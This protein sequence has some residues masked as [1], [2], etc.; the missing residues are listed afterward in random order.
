[1]TTGETLF[2]LDDEAWKNVTDVFSYVQLC[3]IKSAGSGR[4]KR[5]FEA[6]TKGP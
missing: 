5:N 6:V 4:E 2:D 1:M 3:R